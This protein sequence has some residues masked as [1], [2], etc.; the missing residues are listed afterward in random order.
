MN[1]LC[2]GALLIAAM[3]RSAWGSP[4]GTVEGKVFV[5]GTNQ[6]V[7]FVVVKVVNSKIGTITD[8]KGNYRMYLP[9]GF[10][11]LEISSAGMMTV[12]SNSIRVNTGE[13]INLDIPLKEKV[14]VLQEVEINPPLFGEDL[15]SPTSK[16]TLGMRQIELCPGGVCKLPNVVQRLAGINTSREFQDQ[17]SVRGG[18]PNE[19]AYFLEGI[20]VPGMSYFSLPNVNLT[21]T[22]PINLEMLQGLDV[23][24][25]SFPASRGSA[26]SSV[27]E[28][29]MLEGDRYSWS[30]QVQANME[31]LSFRTQ[32]PTSRKSSLNFSGR[33]SSPNSISVY[34]SI[35]VLPLFGDYNFK[36][37]LRSNQRNDFSIISVGGLGNISL[38]KEQNYSE[39]DRYY[40]SVLPQ[41]ESYS[42][43]AGGIWQHYF[44]NGKLKLLASHSRAGNQVRKYQDNVGEDDKLLFYHI[45]DRIENSLKFEVASKV[46]NTGWGYG[47]NV[48]QNAYDNGMK[49]D[50]DNYDGSLNLINYGA[51]VQVSRRNNLSALTLG[52]RMDGSNYSLATANPLSQLSPRFSLSLFVAPEM[53]IGITGASYYELPDYNTLG[54][55]NKEGVLANQ[56]NHTP[57][58]RA[59]HLTCR[60]AYQPT[61][62][63]QISAEYFYKFYSQMPISAIDSTNLVNKAGRYGISG[64]EEVLSIGKGK[65]YGLELMY[66][67]RNLGGLDISSSLT[68]FRSMIRRQG[69]TKEFVPSR[70]DGRLIS[71]ITVGYSLWGNWHIGV[72]GKYFGGAPYTPIDLQSAEDAKIW[73]SYQNADGFTE[74][75]LNS[76]IQT[77]IRVDK[78]WNF[79]S[80]SCSLYVDIAAT[81][82]RQ[83]TVFDTP[84]AGEEK[85]KQVIRTIPGMN[86]TPLFGLTVKF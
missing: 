27:I 6:P 4:Q 82:N 36:W 3:C 79:D 26:L 71:S 19:N 51:Y 64:S 55:R 76:Y 34:S 41:S 22:T 74:L 67:N 48:E 80:W 9:S 63:S 11:Q 33:M 53:T 72:Q 59:D 17:L 40:L 29:R 32:G 5:A 12:V 69:T 77:G 75:R 39:F 28:M 31:N 10:H 73:K 66:Q 43:V 49:D 42:Y 8:S 25:S 65:S 60:V 61:K 68:L 16:R 56:V 58:M 13:T 70:W 84:R 47:A 44:P 83:I 78:E 15:I 20:E 54:Y 30:N 45:S 81:F 14:E 46:K 86:S 24:S 52:I 21:P 35:P 57:Y 1:R 2:V 50:L 7:A 37:K 38:K 23:Y 85:E 18:N 62:Y